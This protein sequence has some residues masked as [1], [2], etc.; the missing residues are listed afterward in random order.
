MINIIRRFITVYMYISHTID[1][2]NN[3][4]ILHTDIL[5][6][7]PDAA[8]TEGSYDLVANITFQL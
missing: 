4:H 8:T 3:Y 6:E 1:Y 7:C 5:I 2:A